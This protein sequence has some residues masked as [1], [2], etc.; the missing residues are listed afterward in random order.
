MGM[1]K[2]K[3]MKRCNALIECS[4]ILS[5][6]LLALAAGAFPASA[7]APSFSFGAR[8]YI[9]PFPQSDRYQVHVIGDGFADGLSGGLRRRSKRTAR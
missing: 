5:A 4:R 1:T 2:A 9:T 3:L 6:M 8:S 7:Q